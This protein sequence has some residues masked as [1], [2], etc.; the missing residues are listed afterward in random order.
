MHTANSSKIEITTFVLIGIPGLEHVHEWI[1]IPICLMYL[2]AILGN[3]TILFVIRTEPS[4]HA[5][6][7]YFLSML[8]ISDLG[9]SLSSLPTMLRTF[10]FN[11]T[12][13]SANACF[14]QEFFIHGFTD[15]ESSVLLVMSFDRFLAIRNPLRY[16]SIL[17][18][19][20]VTKMCLV[21]FIQSMVLM[22]PFPFTLKSLTYCKKSQLSHSYCL[23][24]DVMNLACSDNTV[25]FFYGFFVALC[26]MSDS[27]FIALS[28]VFILKT[29]M[30]IGS[31]K[32]RLKA[33]NTCV[34][35]ICAV[36]IFYMR[37]IALAFM[38]RF[39]NHK[40]PTTMI[41]IADIF[42]LVPPLMNPIVYC[43]KTRQIRKKLLGKFGLK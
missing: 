12:G 11:A 13:I 4:L 37:I 35:H 20:R 18:N 14:A 6:M 21:F 33:L 15:M 3:C 30:G 36:L 40:S 9:L 17:T 25:D 16:N 31:H 26:M 19:A 22:L 5:P 29:V 27:V 39:G 43:V 1:S 10:V 34:S 7:Y 23:H 38:H 2:V 41:L 32:G 24:Q 42:L 8:A 28:Y